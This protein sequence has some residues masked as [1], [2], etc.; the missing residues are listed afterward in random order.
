MCTVKQIITNNWHLVAFHGYQAK[1]KTSI[2]NQSL[3]C[4]GN[5]TFW[6]FLWKKITEFVIIVLYS[7]EGNCCDILLLLFFMPVI[8][9]SPGQRSS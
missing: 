3:A 1:F 8:V 5:G 9:I 6:S 4:L 2:L 7:G